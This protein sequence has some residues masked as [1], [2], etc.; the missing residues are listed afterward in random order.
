MIRYVIEESLENFHFWSGA[1]SNAELLTS[2]EFETVEDYINNDFCKDP[3]DTTINDLFWFDFDFIWE[4]VLGHSIIGGHYVRSDD[5]INADETPIVGGLTK[6]L[7]RERLELSDDEIEILNAMFDK[8]YDDSGAN[9]VNGIIEEIEEAMSD[10]EDNVTDREQWLL[11][12]IQ[13]Y[14]EDHNNLLY[15]NNCIAD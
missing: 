10:N 4:S 15:F 11:E 3:T 5:V 2:D 6:D 9:T 14:I 13:A 7:I 1:K 12:S 8:F